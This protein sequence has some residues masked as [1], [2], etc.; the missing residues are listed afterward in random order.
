ME[1]N[2]KLLETLICPIGKDKLIYNEEKQELVSKKSNLTYKIKNGVPIL[3]P[4][5]PKII[6]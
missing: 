2:T 1:F 3:I 5:Q 4:D 6:D